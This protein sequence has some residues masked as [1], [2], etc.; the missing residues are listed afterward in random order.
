E[1]MHEPIID[2]E[3]WE[4][5]RRLITSRKKVRGN[6]AR[7]DNI[8]AGLIKCADCGYA[9]SVARANRTWNAENIHANYDYQCNS[10]RSEGKTVCTQ[11][12]IV[13]SEL[14]N[15]ILAD[16][17]RL[18]NEALEDDKQ[19]ISSIADK[20]GKVEKDNVRQA[21]REIKKVQKRPN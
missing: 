17:K 15:A 11:H 8:F 21:E 3:E 2:P 18:A 1:G 6:Y 14:R 5:V 13:A 12:R 10:Y 16:I 4:L 20:L 7:Y 19:M 9:L